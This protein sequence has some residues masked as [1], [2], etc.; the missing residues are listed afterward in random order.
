MLKDHHYL[1]SWDTRT[2]YANRHYSRKFQD[3]A[4]AVA[5]A[6]EVSKNPLSECVR[7]MEMES[8][9]TPEGENGTL[10]VSFLGFVAWWEE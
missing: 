4:A 3:Q 1:V 10:H 9:E 5:K 7:V 2:R 8:W 6:R